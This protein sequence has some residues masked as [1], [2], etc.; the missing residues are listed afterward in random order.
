[1][2]SF[3]SLALMA[4]ERLPRLI[5]ILLTCAVAAAIASAQQPS[6]A[7]KR[8]PRLS[9]DDVVRAAPEQPDEESKPAEAAK[10]DPLK[11][12]AGDVSPE[13]SAWRERVK[14]A[15]DRAKALEQQSEETELRVTAIRNQMSV[16]GQTPRDRNQAAAELEETGKR[17]NDLRAQARAAAADLN[18]IVEYG[19]EKGFK[20]AGEPKAT[21]DDGKPNE[22][23]YR[24][25]YAKLTEARQAAE[26]RAQLYEN[27]LRDLNQRI[28]NN[29]VTGDNFYL[30]QLQQ[31]RDEVQA[32]LEEARAAR[33][34][35]QGDI[36]ALMDEARRASVP[37]GVF[38]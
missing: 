3:R 27:R 6:P 12:Q 4:A 2:R 28:T 14:G 35:A 8:T 16:S 15:R 22:Q 10:A 18:K 36:E 32:K 26:R 33:S 23:Y 9:T 38:R 11:A 37:P 1:M 7:K 19:R 25:Q 29:S 34:K 30:S 21:S 13:E 20:E 31:E 5:A 24:A 17:L